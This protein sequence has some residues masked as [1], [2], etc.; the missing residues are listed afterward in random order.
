MGAQR[1]GDGNLVLPDGH[2]LEMLGATKLTDGTI[3]FPDGSTLKRDGSFEVHKGMA[4]QRKVN[5]RSHKFCFFI[6]HM[7][8]LCLFNVGLDPFLCC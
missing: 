7:E 4:T 8:W 5:Q 2:I 3:L 6:F 1:M